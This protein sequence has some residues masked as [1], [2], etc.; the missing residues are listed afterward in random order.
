MATKTPLL[1]FPSNVLFEW[2]Q[3]DTDN[4]NLLR[5][6]N[7]M[8]SLVFNRLSF[9]AILLGLGMRI[10]K[11]SVVHNCRTIWDALRDL[12]SF[13][14]F[15]KRE[16]Y[17]WRSVTF[18]KVSCFTSEIHTQSWVKKEGTV[19]RY[20]II[21]VFLKFSQNLQENSSLVLNK[22]SGLLLLFPLKSPTISRVTSSADFTTVDWYGR[23]KNIPKK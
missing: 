4:W 3:S 10:S 9:L 13:A 5:G 1:T 7:V 17:P 21:K 15:L 12:V 16:E 23:P 18:G 6:F 22:V 20:S 2:S 14:Q 11:S 8:E 19:R